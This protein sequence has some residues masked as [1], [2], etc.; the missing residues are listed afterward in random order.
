MTL[1]WNEQKDL[2]AVVRYLRDPASPVRAERIALWG[3]S[4]GAVTALFYAHSD[5][6]IA[7]L[8]LDS[9]YADLPRLWCAP[10]PRAACAR[11]S[12]LRA[13]TAANLLAK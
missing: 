13:R 6:S 3:R 7:S 11:G 2:A 9:A 12:R 1:G 5:P 4:M 10:L 8:V